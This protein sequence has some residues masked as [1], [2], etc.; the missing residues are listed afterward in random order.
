MQTLLDSP[1]YK[2]FTQDRNKALE[3][4]NLNAQLD[5]SRITH[6]ALDRVTGYLSRISLLRDINASAVQIL[7]DDINA[8]ISKIF[9]TTIFEISNRMMNM[10]KHTFIITYLAELEAIARAT[11][12]TT[13]V[14]L[15]HFKLKI[16]HQKK[17]DTLVGKG[18]QTRIWQIFFRLNQ[19]ITDRFMKAVIIGL[20]P[21]DIVK[22]AMQ[23]YPE[24]KGYKLPPRAIKP[25][26]EADSDNPD[27]PDKEFDFYFGLTNDSDWDMAVQAYKDTELP[28][29]RF[30][31]EGA[32]QDP[33]AGYFK[34]QWELDQEV[35]DDFVQQVR[36]GQVSAAT[37]MGIKEFVWVAIIDNKTCEECC[38]PR[39]GKTTTEIEKMLANGELDKHHCDARVPPAHPYCRCDIGP[40]GNVDEV[41]GPNWK[42][43]DD[44]L[45]T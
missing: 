18:L 26:R 21:A 13:S 4:I 3:Q 14:S 6:E 41:E 34:Y 15:H 33:E 20:S 2:K 22:S 38:Y 44:W 19:D 40:V 36:D 8:V 1:K 37:D 9:Q 29:S 32:S 17:R 23:A 43:F 25:I 28:M 5:I 42:N 31:F 10:R 24:I 16:E 27:K 7:S 39:N 45:S 12:K 35:S 11:K 30:D